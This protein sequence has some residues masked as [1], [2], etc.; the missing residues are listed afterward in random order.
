MKRAFA[1]SV[2]LTCLVAG[3]LGKPLTKERPMRKLEFNGQVVYVPVAEKLADPFSSTIP[4]D[5]QKTDMILNEEQKEYIRQQ[6]EEHKD[7]RTKRKAVRDVLKRWTKV[8][9]D[10]IVPFTMDSPTDDIPYIYAAMD[11]WSTKTCV[12]FET[13]SSDRSSTLGHNQWLRFH[14]ADGCSSY[15]GR[16]PT[17]KMQPQPIT[18]GTGCLEVT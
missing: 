12:K 11:H 5:E 9:G 3:I 15:V 17:S 10:V 16:Q 14:K 6:K 2:L 13:Y 18:L 7:G 8:G 4:G 1:T